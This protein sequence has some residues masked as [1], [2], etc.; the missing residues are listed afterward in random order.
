MQTLFTHRRGHTVFIKHDAANDICRPARLAPLSWTVRHLECIASL[1]EMPA[2]HVVNT[3]LATCRHIPVPIGKHRRVGPGRHDLAQEQVIR[4][5]DMRFGEYAALEP[6]QAAVEQRRT[7]L[8]TG[9]GTRIERR[10][11][12][13]DVEPTCRV[14]RAS[15]RDGMF[16]ANSP[17]ASIML[18]VSVFLSITT[19]TLGGSKSSGIDQAAAITL[20]AS[21]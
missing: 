10:E 14:R 8:L 3:F 13:P 16:S 1:K 6:G 2:S 11:L 12:R 19:A 17:D 7:H 20:T 4:V 18:R 5:L 21:P 9:P 15:S